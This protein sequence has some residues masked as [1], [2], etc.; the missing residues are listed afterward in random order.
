MITTNKRSVGNRIDMTTGP[1]FGNIIRFMMPLILTNLLQHF[2]NAAD[3]M[4]VEFSSEPDAVGAVGSTTTFLSLIT[5][6]FIGFSV[7]AN[8]VVAKNIGLKDKDAISR[9]VHTSICMSLIFG[10]IGSLIGIVLTRPIYIAMGYAGNLLELAVRYSYIYLACMPFLSLTNFLSSIMRAQ[11]DT[12]TTLYILT[13]T[14]LLNI[15]LNF[16]FVLGMGLSVEGVAIATAIA[17]LVSAVALWICLAKNGNDCTISL[18]KL[19]ISRDQFVEIARI[20]FP[21]G[22]QNAFFSISNMII[23]SSIMDINNAVTPPNSEYAPVIKGNTAVANIES[24]IF[25]ALAATTVTSSTVTAQN[26]GARNCRR[27][28]TAFGY[29]CLISTV[30]AVVMSG[31]GMLFRDPILLLYGVKNADDIL[32]S[33]N[34]NTAITRIIWKWPAFFIYAIMNACAGTIRGLGKSSTSAIITFFGTC[35]FRIVWMYTVFLYFENLEC[36]YISYPISWLITGIFFL[37]VVFILFDKKIKED[38]RENARTF[39]DNSEEL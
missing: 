26:M 4:I 27:A 14:G 30:I 19:R 9:G 20:G 36:I 23:Q 32:S 28:R 6:I 25:N 29:I 35:V 10:V 21:A 37:F 13:A 22:I 3:I 39:T 31:A 38:D 8:V 12:K 1:M 15:V 2:Y 24:F 16:F 17:N 18:Q 34:Y 33:I 5:N 11:G 7:G